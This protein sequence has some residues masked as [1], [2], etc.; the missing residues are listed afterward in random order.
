MLDVQVSTERV[1]VSGSR[2][3]HFRYKFLTS[4]GFGTGDRGLQGKRDT[5]K[6]GV[7]SMNP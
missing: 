5:G 4:G 7:S 1:M 6:S 2:A 3:V